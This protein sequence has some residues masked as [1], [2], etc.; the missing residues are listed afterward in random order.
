MHP[1]TLQILNQPVG[2]MP[3]ANEY[4]SFLKCGLSEFKPPKE[5]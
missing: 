1:N 3:D 2:Y 4:I 5:K